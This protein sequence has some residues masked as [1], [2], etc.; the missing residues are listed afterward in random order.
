MK[1][2]GHPLSSCTRKVLMTLAEKGTTAEFVL[3]DLL[4]HDHT[5]P[6]HLALHAFGRVPV[7]EDGDFRM[8]ESRAIIRYL[9]ARLPGAALV[10]NDLREA[11][12][13]DQ[14]LSVDASYVAPHTRTLAIERLMKPHAGIPVD[15]AAAKDAEDQLERT[16]VT[17][18]RTLADQPYLVGSE[19][20]L[21][22]ISL[23]PYVA[24][25]P[26]LSAAHVAEK[27]PHV[28]AWLGRMTARPS[29]KAVAGLAN[30]A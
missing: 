13:M 12:R 4:K 2:Y 14:W 30:P 7:L 17:I 29:W 25:L 11:A 23:L 3:V 22:D 21:A 18:D 24:S 19:L 20:T 6:T 27:T 5:T 15:A 9:D 10:P 16:L 28:R 8:I 1:V 26:L